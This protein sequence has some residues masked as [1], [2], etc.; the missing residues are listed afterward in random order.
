MRRGERLPHDQA[1][2]V[3]CDPF[4]AYLE[5]ALTPSQR[6]SVVVDI[7]ALCSSPAGRHPLSSQG[8]LAGWNTV[9]VLGGEH[10]V[11]F[12]SR[13]VNGVGLIEVLCAGPRRASAVYDLAAHLVATG[14][15]A[16]DEVIEIWQS[17]IL[18]DIVA[19]AVGLDGWDYRPPPAPEG[20]IRAAVTSGLLD[21]AT[22]RLLSTDEITEAMTHGW[23]DAGPDPV[24]ALRAAVARARA[25]VDPGDLTRFLTSRAADRCDALL[26]RVG[27]RCIRRSD[28]PGPHRAR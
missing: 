23:N 2:I 15:L 9:S 8:G 16:D 1:Q 28:H 25:G 5:D 24:A 26:P 6:A 14:L 19:E 4:V 17:L 3:F 27:A 11:V 22:A 13:I 10:R 7:V 20:L 21:E 12:A 18:L